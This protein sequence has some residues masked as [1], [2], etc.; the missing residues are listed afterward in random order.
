MDT[1]SPLTQL[2]STENSSSPIVDDRSADVGTLGSSSLS[3][4]QTTALGRPSVSM[5]TPNDAQSV[6]NTV[7]SS[8]SFE[9]YSAPILTTEQPPLRQPAPRMTSSLS[10]HEDRALLQHGRDHRRYVANA[11]I[12]SIQQTTIGAIGD[13]RRFPIAVSFS[14]EGAFIP[15]HTP[16][17]N[18]IDNINL[19]KSK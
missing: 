6:S 8:S 7:I 13:G 15:F 1:E 12:R 5:N 14:L 10:K 16:I 9:G 2:H 19:V 17:F 11:P 3:V 18:T 4:V